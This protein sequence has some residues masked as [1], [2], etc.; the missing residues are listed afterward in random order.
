MK[1]RNFYVIL[2]A[3]LILGTGCNPLRNSHYQEYLSLKYEVPECTQNYT[4]SNSTSL[5]GTAKFFKRG[6]NLVTQFET[7]NGAQVL[8]LKNMTQ[9]DP[10]VDPLPIKFAEVAVYDSSNQI[11]Q[12]GR[13][14]ISG[15]LKALDATSNLLIPKKAGQFTVRVF[16][17][18]NHDLTKVTASAV[19]KQDKY[20]NEVYFISGLASSNGIDDTN[21]NL[22]AYAR[23]TESLT[24][25]G[26]AF[27]ILND[28]FTAYK[29]LDDNTGTTPISCLNNKFNIYWK[30]GFN[31]A[32]YVYPD[33]NPVLLANATFYDPKIS[34][35]FISGGKLGNFT[36]ESAAHFDDYVIIHEFAH[37]IENSCGSLLSPGGP[38]YI[39]TRTDPRLA[40][41]EGWAN[42]F[43]AEVMYNYVVKTSE[44]SLT[45]N[46]EFKN[47]MQTAGIANT[48]WTYLFA[49]EGFSDS[50]QNIGSGNGFMFD[51]TKAGNNPDS[52]QM[53]GYIGQAF[54][55]VDPTRY[56]GEGHFR[57]GAI[58]RG[59]FKLSNT[60]GGTC[61]TASPIPFE[62][63]WKSM[64]KITGIGQ[65]GYTFKS[66]ANFME[67]LKALSTWD[68]AKKTFNEA[69]TSEALHIYSDGAFTSGGVNKWLPY[70]TYLSTL[71]GAACGVGSFHIEPRSDDPVLTGTN[72]DQRYSNHFYT[73][74]LNLLSS[75]DQI[76]VV[77][78]KTAGT[79]T[80]FDIL[81]FQENYLFNGDYV[82]PQYDT[83][84]TTCKVSYQPSRTTSADVI[85]SDRRSGSISTKVIRDLQALDH[86]KRY[87][88]NI[89]A[90]T[91]N[92]SINSTTEYSYQI[93]DQTGVNNICP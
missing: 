26:G 32:Q 40:W 23:Q 33:K 58:T 74:D 87:L 55:K 12:C 52:W 93:K 88:L 72:S 65:A 80:E 49:S 57:E 21:I 43:A 37:H 61:I 1:S 29:F 68:A 50:A 39:I 70:G 38:H 2:F 14:D 25:D 8:K 83:D 66:S 6:V 20:T 4:Y 24:V 82:C 90:Y 41:A 31:P 18:M 71:T 73:I 9:G 76:Q 85:K 10:L 15:N 36:F 45:I 84:G 77:F 30:L 11:V 46:P 79:D 67:R 28:I 5:T 86:N 91:A 59:L 63:M 42:Y 27:N 34:S 13:T 92:K 3:F 7:V 17:R 35:L 60:C 47:K 81:L 54:D 51:L 48:S 56:P 53:G 78:S 22:L 75:V 44:N 19:V 69:A 64:D 16:A 89:R 62:A